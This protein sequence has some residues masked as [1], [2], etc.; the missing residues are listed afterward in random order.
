[1]FLP[2][3]NLLDIHNFRNNAVTFEKNDL[4]HVSYSQKRL[5]CQVENIFIFFPALAPTANTTTPVFT[6]CNERSSCIGISAAARFEA[7]ELHLP[8]LD[9]R[10]GTR[11]LFDSRG[12]PARRNL[13]AVGV[14]SIG[15]RQYRGGGT[16]RR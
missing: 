16:L 4:S 11:S 5:S 9:R 1:M 12:E 8:R 3:E 6:K 14:D 7:V 10:P 13:R 2:P 15:K